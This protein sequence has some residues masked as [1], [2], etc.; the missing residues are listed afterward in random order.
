M[1]WEQIND[2]FDAFYA[3]YVEGKKP[4]RGRVFSGGHIEIWG[5]DSVA[6]VLHD[7]YTRGVTNDEKALDFVRNVFDDSRSVHAEINYERFRQIVSGEKPL[8][9][10]DWVW[11]DE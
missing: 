7:P 9:N 11:H 8:T 3:E 4:V 6:I 10:E 2:W 1:N 5:R